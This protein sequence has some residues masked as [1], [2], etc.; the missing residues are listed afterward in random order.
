MI[1]NFNLSPNN[2][3]NFL[4]KVQR[5]DLSLGYVANVT[6]KQTTRNLLQNDAYWFFITSFGEHLGYDKDEL[7]EILRFKF[8]YE[9]MEIDGKEHRRLLSTTKLSVKAMANYLDQCL[10]FAGEHGFYWEF[11]H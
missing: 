10:R 6:V 9:L 8:L 3:D 11:T 7:H 4:H 5:L 1:K 2:L